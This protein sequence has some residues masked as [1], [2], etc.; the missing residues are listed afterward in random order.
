M[1]LLQATP[2]NFVSYQSTI[3]NILSNASIKPIGTAIQGVAIS[4][5]AVTALVGI[6]EAFFDGGTFAPP[7][8]PC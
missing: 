4:L 2:T 8:S 6:Y 5:V 3:T 1:M 7:P